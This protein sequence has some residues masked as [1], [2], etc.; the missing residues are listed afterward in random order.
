MQAIDETNDDHLASMIQSG[1][2]SACSDIHTETLL[3]VSWGEPDIMQQRL[4][5]SAAKLKP[6]QRGEVLQAR[7]RM[8][9]AHQ[10]PVITQRS[11]PNH[12]PPAIT[13]PSHHYRPASPLPSTQHPSRPPAS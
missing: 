4:E 12:R 6:E 1:L 5:V 9:A 13:T 8:G 11:R 3:T 10:P 2:L 7:P